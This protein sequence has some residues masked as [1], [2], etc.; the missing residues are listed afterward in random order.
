MDLDRVQWSNAGAKGRAGRDGE[1]KSVAITVGVARIYQALE[2]GLWMPFVSTEPYLGDYSTHPLGCAVVA[3]EAH[4]R[5]GGL[6]RR[7]RSAI[8]DTF[9]IC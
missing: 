4:R 5:E 1:S 6:I 3:D 2:Q 7:N 8:N 9:F